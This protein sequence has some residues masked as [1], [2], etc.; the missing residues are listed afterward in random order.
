MVNTTTEVNQP[1]IGPICQN[2]TVASQ[3]K[4]TFTNINPGQGSCLICDIFHYYLQDKDPIPMTLG[5]GYL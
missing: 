3:Y 4:E 5:M 2:K 1:I